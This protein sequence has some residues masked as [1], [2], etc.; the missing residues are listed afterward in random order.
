M[1]RIDF[2]QEM[3]GKTRRDYVARV[4]Q[5]DKA[6]CS[7][8][9]KR[10]GAEYWDGPRQYGYGGYR[11]DGRWRPLADKLASHYAIKPG[12]RVLDV[13]CGK[14]FLLHELAQSVPGI[15]IFG[16]DISEYG[17]ADGKPEVK[18][19]LVVGNARALP[20]PSAS[21]DVVLSLGTLHNLPVELAIDAFAEIERVGRSPRKY[22]MVESFRDE[23]ER[24]NLMYWQLTCES[25]LSPSSWAWVI[26]RAGYRGDHG[27][28]FF[29]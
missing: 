14:G 20:F 17:I 27:F 13:G 11:Y 18:P 29:E 6:E 2:L 22:V 24:A 15:E 8:V 3:H 10:F 23:R 16:L 5:F 19:H 21:F 9:A 25:L 4:V 12:D 26:E 1:A 7:T 28:I